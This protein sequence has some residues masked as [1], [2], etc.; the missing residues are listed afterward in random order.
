M[1]R[2]DCLFFLALPGLQRI[3]LGASDSLS[4]LSIHVAES[5]RYYWATPIDYLQMMQEG[6]IFLPPPQTLLV[7][8]LLSVGKEV[9]NIRPIVEP[10][11]GQFGKG[12]YFVLPGDE[13]YDYDL[14]TTL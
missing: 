10:L 3:N 9:Y 8:F 11:L 6:T 5:S 7:H 12:R 13:E 2:F 4:E 1:G 14:A